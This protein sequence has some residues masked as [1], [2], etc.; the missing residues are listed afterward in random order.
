M[1]K[2]QSQAHLMTKTNYDLSVQFRKDLMNTYDKVGNRGMT[3]KQAYELTVKQ[4]AP[5]YYVTAKQA[6]QVI[7]K[8]MK[9]DFSEVRKMKENKRRLYASLFNVTCK[10]MNKRCYRKKKLFYIMQFAVLEPAPEFFVNWRSFQKIFQCVQDG[11]FKDSPK[12]YDFG[13][14]KI[15]NFEPQDKHEFKTRTYDRQER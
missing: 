11:H 8:M 10:L 3:Q 2:Q 15:E 4:P 13:K 7:S 6:Y 1:Q 14:A 5:R 12:W 9:G